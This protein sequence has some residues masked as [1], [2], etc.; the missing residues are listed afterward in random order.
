MAVSLKC[1]LILSNCV[2][3]TDEKRRSR[4]T[5]VASQ[6]LPVAHETATTWTSQPETTL[7]QDLVEKSWTIVLGEELYDGFPVLAGPEARPV[8]G[9]HQEEVLIRYLALDCLYHG[10]EGLV[11]TEGHGP[12]RQYGPEAD[13]RSEEH[14][15]GLVPGTELQEGRL[16]RGISGVPSVGPV[17]QRPRARMWGEMNREIEAEMAADYSNQGA[18][19][20]FTF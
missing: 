4:D 17:H 14:H 10:P 3:L 15:P 9:T 2:T 11:I 19:A 6:D 1:E 5:I 20:Y 13:V 12:I 7:V 18:E 8:R 16:V